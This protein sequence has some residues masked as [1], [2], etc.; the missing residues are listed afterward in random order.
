MGITIEGGIGK[1]FR[2]EGSTD[3]DDWLYVTTLRNTDGVLRF[4]DPSGSPKCF[5]RVIV[6]P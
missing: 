6:V 4:V 2:I 3:L 1:Q 5:Y